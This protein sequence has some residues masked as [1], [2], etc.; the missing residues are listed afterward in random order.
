MIQLFQKNTSM[1]LGKLIS[2]LKQ[3]VMYI[4]SFDSFNYIHKYAQISQDIFRQV[5]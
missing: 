1:Y 5:V 2:P 3:T 4:C